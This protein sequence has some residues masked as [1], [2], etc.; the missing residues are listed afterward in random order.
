M[1]DRN[2]KDKKKGIRAYYYIKSA[3]HKKKGSKRKRKKQG[4]YKTTRKQ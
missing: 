4:K 1:Y 2:P 3:I